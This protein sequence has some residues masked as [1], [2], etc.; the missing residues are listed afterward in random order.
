LIEGWC[1]YFSAGQ[2]L[3]GRVRVQICCH[4]Q[5]LVTTTFKTLSL[6]SYCLRKNANGLRVV[7]IY[8]PRPPQD[9]PDRLRAP[10]RLPDASWNLP[11]ASQM[12]PR[13][14]QMLPRCLPD[15]SQMFPCRKCVARRQ[16]RH[17]VD[18]CMVVREDHS[19]MEPLSSIVVSLSGGVCK[20]HETP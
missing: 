9:T 14:S 12:H 8:E 6:F 13:I 20:K 7:S 15:V 18:C 19:A 11:D 3:G 4:T 17:C 10:R 5:Y 1:W 16:C 2:P